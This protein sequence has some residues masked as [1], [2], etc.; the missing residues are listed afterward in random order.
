ML[1][2][3]RRIR[4]KLL[5]EGNLKRYLIYA[6]GEIL[7]VMVGI[8]LALQVNNSNEATKENILVAGYLNN[9]SKNIKT[10]LINLDF[11]R[12]KRDSSIQGSKIF[13]ELAEQ[14]IITRDEFLYYYKVFRKY[15]PIVERS[16]IPDKSGF[17][18]L[19]NSG[20]MRKIQGK[21]IESKLYEYYGL[22][23]KIEK[24]EKSLEDFVNQMEFEMFNQ[25]VYFQ[26]LKLSRLIQIDANLKNLENIHV[27]MNNPSFKGANFR[28][29]VSGRMI[30]RYN[31]L[32][33]KGK[34]LIDL[35]E[36]E[37]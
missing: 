21:K 16:F 24:G 17:E 26:Y 10:D 3:Y 12:N 7:L 8:L 9:I 22:M 18:A 20:Y 23:T 25:D 35:I 32:E 37:I 31:E 27:I 36:M 34:E 33:N 6:I 13:L 2:F 11:T 5:D 30:D 19:N 15:N 29:S 1:K 4:R 14:K 28:V